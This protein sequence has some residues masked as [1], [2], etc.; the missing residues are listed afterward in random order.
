[1]PAAES[2]VPDWP[3]AYGK[4]LFRGLIKQTP[5]DFQVIERLGFSPSGEGEHDFLWLEK[6]GANTAWVARALARHA[7][8]RP[9]DVGYSGLK[10]RHAVTRQWFSVRRPTG[11]GTD[12]SS[13]ALDG[14]RILDATR[15]RRKLRRGV[16]TGNRFRI[17]VR[18]AGVDAGALAARLGLIGGRGVPNY[19]GAQRFG[20]GG[21][22]LAMAEKLFDGGRLRRDKRALA[23]SAARGLIFNHVLA[24]R[25]RQATWDQGM[26]GDVFNLDGSNSLFT[27]PVPDS[28]LAS[29]LEALD[30]HPT[31]P[32]WGVAGRDGN[33][34][35]NETESAI[36]GPQ[37]AIAAGLEAAGARF[38]RRALRLGVRDLTWT[39]EADRIILAFE[40][41]TGGYA[42]T[43]LR[44]LC[45][46][47]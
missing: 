17:V 2:S 24:E 15:N 16:H 41:R 29:R 13:F 22:N 5:G 11:A 4:P 39:A 3:R 21:A 7:A 33:L 18:H 28:D 43:A 6:T 37:A 34:A 42:T 38:G 10:D 1:M 27:A 20:R 30:A 31:G 19:F 46:V 40:L 12:W 25:V 44:E 26:P 32:L 14:V 9:D 23:L 47:D 36:V 45:D 8:V 35:P